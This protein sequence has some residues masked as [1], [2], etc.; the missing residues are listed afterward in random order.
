MLKFN[1]P[2]IELYYIR[3]GYYIYGKIEKVKRK[4]DVLLNSIFRP[5]KI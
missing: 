5:I 4:A 3:K 1:P 2:A